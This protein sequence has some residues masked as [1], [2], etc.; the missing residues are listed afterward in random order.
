M[1]N[2]IA[3]PDGRR[4]RA[5]YGFSSSAHASHADHSVP[6]CENR[7]DRTR[8]ALEI[9]PCDVA[10]FKAMAFVGIQYF[11]PEALAVRSHDAQR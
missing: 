5:S 11:A 6:E 1:T 3:V 9:T 4:G 8:Q 7:I 2:S 10:V